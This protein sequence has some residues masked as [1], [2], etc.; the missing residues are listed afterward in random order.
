[1]YSRVGV[2]TGALPPMVVMPEIQGVTLITLGVK[3]RTFN[4]N[5]LLRGMLALDSARKPCA[6]VTSALLQT[7]FGYD[8][9]C[10]WQRNY[11]MLVVS[12]LPNSVTVAKTVPVRKATRPLATE[13]SDLTEHGLLFIG[14]EDI[15]RFLLVE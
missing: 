2:W 13:F 7:T 5:W 12:K 6:V 8:R 3:D 11:F 14:A 15:P 4:L 9:D 10:L 1:M